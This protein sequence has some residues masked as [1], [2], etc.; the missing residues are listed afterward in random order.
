MERAVVGP[1]VLQ[2]GARTARA[3]SSGVHTL[4]PQAGGRVSRAPSTPDPKP[5]T[6]NPQHASRWDLLSGP[7]Y[8][9]ERLFPH[10]SS[11]DADI[12][13]GEPPGTLHPNPFISGPDSLTCAELFERAA[14]SSCE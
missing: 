2:P 5:P 9:N 10:S 14:L 1:R 7:E 8:L 3:S 13:P 4:I 12:S 11:E 6:P